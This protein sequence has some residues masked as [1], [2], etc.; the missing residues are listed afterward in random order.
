VFNILQDDDY[1]RGAQSHS[2]WKKKEAGRKI[3]E[4]RFILRES[5]SAEFLPLKMEAVGFDKGKN[6][7]I[8]AH[9]NFVANPEIVGY[10]IMA[11]RI[12]CLCSGCLKSFQ[13]SDKE[14]YSNPCDDCNHWSMYLGWNDWTKINFQKGRDCDVNDL[15]GA[16]QWTL[17]KIGERMALQIVIS[18]YG[19]YLVDDTMKYYLVQSSDPWDLWKQM[20]MWQERESGFANDCG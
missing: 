13:K 3:T 8:R 9:H 18:K 14:R 6:M 4:R 17:N 15:L 12:P 19:A 11:R 20:E 16:Q 1:V 5:G 10:S 7:G 2:S